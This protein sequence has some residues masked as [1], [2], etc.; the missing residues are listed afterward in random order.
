[1]IQTLLK[2]I[3]CC[4][5]VSVLLHSISFFRSWS[6][7]DCHITTVNHHHQ[8]HHCQDGVE[9]LQQ[10][11]DLAGLA[12]HRKQ[13]CKSGEIFSTI[14]LNVILHELFVWIPVYCDISAMFA[15]SLCSALIDML[16]T[17]TP[18]PLL[19][20]H[21]Q[22]FS[23]DPRHCITLRISTSVALIHR[24]KT[25]TVQSRKR[26][27]SPKQNKHEQWDLLRH[28]PTAC[29]IKQRFSCCEVF[30]V[31]ISTFHWQISSRGGRGGSE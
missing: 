1:M 16:A 7:E 23:S 21:I 27:Q 30:N 25:S 3:K 8:H 4:V 19:G 9:K 13:N 28:Y 12:Q 17:L 22:T 14:N 5:Q 18:F 26:S 10:E 2:H 11:T 24:N 6:T 20:S 15:I 29:W 31:H